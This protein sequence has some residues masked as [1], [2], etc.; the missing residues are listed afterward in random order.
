MGGD[1]ESILHAV[2]DTGGDREDVL[3]IGSGLS[4]G[5]IGDFIAFYKV[6]YPYSLSGEYALLGLGER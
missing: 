2:R 3:D 5:G 4:V 1:G 6:L